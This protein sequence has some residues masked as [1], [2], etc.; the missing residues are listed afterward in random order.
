MLADE[1][2]IYRELWIG[3]APTQRK[4]GERLTDGT[5]LNGGLYRDGNRDTIIENL[6]GF[7]GAVKGR[8]GAASE[9]GTRTV[10]NPPRRLEPTSE[11]RIQTPRYTPRYVVGHWC[12]TRR[13][14]DGKPMPDRKVFPT[15]VEA[16][17]Y[18]AT[19]RNAKFPPKVEQLN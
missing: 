2:Q 4:S 15:K 7:V 13:A 9:V 8:K 19:V 11:V 14:T 3:L 10:D 5:Y 6:I 16:E 18:A 12:V 17:E 1:A